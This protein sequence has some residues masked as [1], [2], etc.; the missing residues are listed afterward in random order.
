M[1][2]RDGW[3]WVRLKPRE[4]TVARFS[5]GLWNHGNRSITASTI[6]DLGPYYMPLAA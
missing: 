2:Q 1:A 5:N 6:I 3:Y 4:W